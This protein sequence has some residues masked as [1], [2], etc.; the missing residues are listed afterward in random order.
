V[1]GPEGRILGQHGFVL[2]FSPAL[3]EMEEATDCWSWQ[4][5]QRGLACLIPRC[6]PL[7]CHRRETSP[8]L[9]LVPVEEKDQDWVRQGRWTGNLG[10]VSPKLLAGLTLSPRRD[11]RWPA[12]D[13]A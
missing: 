3:I 8:A 11:E 12:L 10:K 5:Q 4:S 2:L 7:S 6:S 1:E 13:C 9:D